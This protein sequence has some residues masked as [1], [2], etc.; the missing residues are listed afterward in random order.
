MRYG[1]ITQEENELLTR[2]GL[3]TPAGELFRRYWQPAA[4]S[5]EL[6]VGGAPIPLRMLSEDLVLFRNEILLMFIGAQE[7]QIAGIVGIAQITGEVAKAGWMPVLELAALLS[8]NLAILNILPIPALDGGRLVFVALEWVR[9]GRRISPE[10]E[11]K[12][13][14]V[15]FAV[16]IALM[17][18]VTGFD[19]LRIYRGESF[20]P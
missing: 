7:A 5:E 19:I 12:V 3:G 2:T 11:G 9:R 14:L 15:G 13:H 17:V 16:L 20:L 6:P 4:L 8:L 1:A 10:R 18:V